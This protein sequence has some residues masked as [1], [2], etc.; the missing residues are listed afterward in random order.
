MSQKIALSNDLCPLSLYHAERSGFSRSNK[1][2]Y[3]RFSACQ[4]Q[5]SPPRKTFGLRSAQP[6]KKPPV[7]ATISSKSPKWS[8]F[9]NSLEP[10]LP[11]KTDVSRAACVRSRTL[12]PTRKT[13]LL[14]L[15][16]SPA[17]FLFLV[18]KGVSGG[19]LCH[20][21]QRR[22]GFS[23]HSRRACAASS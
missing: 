8:D 1:Q 18:V 13:L 11:Q 9:L 10:I 22:R 23:R 4:S 21:W 14:F 20:K 7:R 15:R 6:K 17:E 2:K 5:I 12:R 16:F 3:T 19:S